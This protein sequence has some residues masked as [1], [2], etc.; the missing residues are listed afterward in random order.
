MSPDNRENNEISASFP[1]SKSTVPNIL[2]LYSY[3]VALASLIMFIFS[4]LAFMQSSGVRAQERLGFAAFFIVTAILAGRL[5]RASRIV[6]FIYCV[7]CLI[8]VFMSIYTLVN[9]SHIPP[10]EY[11]LVLGVTIILYIIPVI[12]AAK[13]FKTLR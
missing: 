6:F 8:M 3:F 9:I 4:A 5:A 1:E 12:I 7:L 13:N 11:L 2:K 10:S